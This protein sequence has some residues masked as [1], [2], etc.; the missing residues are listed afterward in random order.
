MRRGNAW[1]TVH[2]VGLAATLLC[3][4]AA[5]ADFEAGS[6]AWD[7]GRHTEAVS[8]WQSAAAKGDGRAMFRLGRAFREGIGVPADY[9]EAYM[10]LNLA[11]G[12]GYTEAAAERDALAAVMTA[13][14]RAEAQR[15]ARAWR[16]G[17]QPEAAPGPDSDPAEAAATESPPERALREAQ[18]LLAQL[19]LGIG[20]PD[21]VWGAQSMAAYGNFLR[22]AGM[23]ETDQLTPEG[24]RALRAA[25]RQ[26]ES[27]AT[28]EA[29]PPSPALPPDVLHQAV[30]SGNIDRLQA[31]LAAGADV[32]A[33]DD[34]GW[35]ALMHA[36]NKGYT[37]MLPALI[38]GGADLDYRAADGATALFVA[39]LL[40]HSEIVDEL[41]KAGADP[42]IRG[43]RGETAE[44]L[45]ARRIV[46]EKYGGS[47]EALHAAL[48]ANEGPAVIAELLDR[49]ADLVVR[50]EIPNPG[51]PEWP[52]LYMPL[53]V[54][55][56]YNTHP[57]AIELLLDRGAAIDAQVQTKY[58]D[59]PSDNGSSAIEL[60]AMRNPNPSVALELM[61]RKHG[62]LTGAIID[63]AGLL[64][65]AAANDNPD[66]ARTLLDLGADV[67][68]KHGDVGH[69]PLHWAASS[70]ASAETALLLIERGADLNART[71]AGNQYD[72]TP[73]ESTAAWNTSP[74]AIMQA[75]VSREG[76]QGNTNRLIAV[77]IQHQNHAA[78]RALP[79][80]T[81]GN[82]GTVEDS[83]PERVDCFFSEESEGSFCSEP[84]CQVVHKHGTFF[85]DGTFRAHD[86]A[87]NNPDMIKMVRLFLDRGAADFLDPRNNQDTNW[88]T[89]CMFRVATGH[90]KGGV[91][92]AI[93]NW[94]NA[95]SLTLEAPRETRQN[96]RAADADRC[97][98]PRGC[99]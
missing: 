78:V 59:G 58:D 69:T 11:A 35:T 32:N 10:W 42:T 81:R 38:E 87:M 56:A 85:S 21:G 4:V 84:L 83:F 48:R 14:E 17:R 91:K 66:V 31:A 24:L 98:N 37:L 13:E 52:H 74:A 41:V 63:N 49:G 62:E 26:R 12:E 2:G 47:R 7:A 65:Y 45:M 76:D 44:S 5:Q 39:A 88:G 77:A 29:S 82:I 89:Q 86:S 53:H 70:L 99:P 92:S 57:G 18:R 93:Q 33:L 15:L 40:G 73:L 34:R 67:N 75:L 19:G 22:G 50:T 90:A 61:G 46:D 36:A 3:S 79:A 16:A 43:P 54:A 68:M 20:Q 51:Y 94:M 97:T 64:H 80:Y 9:V 71:T 1:M 96:R 25:V 28:G 27:T 30:L 6:A 72:Y 95:H 8:E 55:A 60:A 23:L